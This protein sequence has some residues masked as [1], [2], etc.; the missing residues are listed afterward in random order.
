MRQ[1]E[2]QEY[3]METID[4]D[5]DPRE[6]LAGI[7]ELKTPYKPIPYAQKRKDGTKV[8]IRDRA[9]SAAQ[10]FE[11]KSGITKPNPS[12]KGKNNKTKITINV[13]FVL[14]GSLKIIGMFAKGKIKQSMN[15]V[16]DEFVNYAK[17]K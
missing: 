15:M 5:L 6:K 2:R 8:K 16:M 17:S 14:G 7:R 12:Q 4:K 3:V 13:D 1:M 11:Q 9:E 10:F